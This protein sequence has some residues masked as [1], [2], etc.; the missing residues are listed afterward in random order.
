MPLFFKE[1]KKVLFL[2]IPKTAGTSVE[3]AFMDAGYKDKY[4]I[5]RSRGDSGNT[6]PCS[7]QHYQYGLVQRF[8]HPEEGSDME[9]FA[10]VRN[11]FTRCISEYFW[12]GGGQPQDYND[13]FF[14]GLKKYVFGNLQT[15]IDNEK[16]WQSDKE[17][18]IAR[19]QR[20]PGDNHWR[21]QWHFIGPNTKV[22]KYE[23][24]DDV[25]FPDLKEKYG[26]KK[27]EK[28]YTNVS[29]DLTRPTKFPNNFK[30][31]NQFKDRYIKVYGQ[32]HE[33]FEYPL[34]F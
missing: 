24:L 13:N 12:M 4:L 28:K 15:Y 19:N 18:F 33:R 17:N 10:I 2:H 32:D 5:I 31:D 3:Y 34:P 14:T 6:N 7:P 1:D 20:F 30:V 8:I 11:P 25:V 9:E 23:E 27:L 22:Y 29:L 16:T 21:P 26:I